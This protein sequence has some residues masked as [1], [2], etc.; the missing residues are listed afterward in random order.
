M[1]NV[2]VAV[3]ERF[4]KK[5]QEDKGF[6]KIYLDY[7]SDPTDKKK[8]YLDEMYKRY[9]RQLI[10]L[11]YLRKMLFFEAKRFDKKVR[12]I[13]KR[14]FSLDV[15]Y[16][17][18]LTFMDLLEDENGEKVLDKVFDSELKELFS[19]EKLCRE[20][21]AMT[22]KQKEVLRGLYVS[23]LTEAVLAKQL[24]VTQQAV[25][26]THRSIINKLRKVVV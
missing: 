22:N 10:S 15:D 3:S 8:E 20:I 9:E 1:I 18:N 25:S 13:N 4:Q 6:E 19:D 17:E 16:D 5:L 23:A 12:E 24:G 26:K 7:L 21:L 11:K 2:N 14:Q